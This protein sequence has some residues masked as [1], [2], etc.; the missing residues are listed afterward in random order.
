MASSSIHLMNCSFSLLS[1]LFF[2]AFCSFH[3]EVCPS[4]LQL[5]YLVCSIGVTVLFNYAAAW[6]SLSISNSTVTVRHN[7][8]S[9]RVNACIIDAP[10]SVC[11]YLGLVRNTFV[12]SISKCFSSINLSVPVHFETGCLG[13][14]TSSCSCIFPHIFLSMA[15]GCY[16]WI[17]TH[18]QPFI[19]P[20]CGGDIRC[21]I[22]AISLANT[23][24]AMLAI[25][26]YV[27]TYFI[28]YYTLHCYSSP[29]GVNV[30]E[31]S[32]PISVFSLFFSVI[33]STC[34]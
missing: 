6:I 32:L 34:I 28:G 19:L 29:R 15:F 12:T 21:Y 27:T 17:Y 22:H 31:G 16:K 11:S 10:L 9:F 13:G 24:Y 14:S 7:C 30:A 20:L 5:V 3:S 2:F 1:F 23:T 8:C 18:V 26:L 4:S 33:S 25:W